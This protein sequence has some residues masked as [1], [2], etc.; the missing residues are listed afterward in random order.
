LSHKNNKER[1]RGEGRE[2]RKEESGS[3][4]PILPKETLTVLFLDD[5]KEDFCVF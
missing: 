3:S 5:S 1:K 2:G 4:V